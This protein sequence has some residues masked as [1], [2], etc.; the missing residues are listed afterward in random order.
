MY[1]AA[2]VCIKPD[3]RRVLQ[4]VNVFAPGQSLS[5]C[6]E[7]NFSIKWEISNI[8]LE[9]FHMQAHRFL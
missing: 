9:Y 7:N 6:M 3:Y 8:D 4:I 5:Y 1:A 2:Y